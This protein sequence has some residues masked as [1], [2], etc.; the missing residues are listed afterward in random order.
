MHHTK[1]RVFGLTCFILQKNLVSRVCELSLSSLFSLLKGSTACQ[2]RDVPFYGISV[3]IV[4]FPSVFLLKNGLG[5]AK[6][7][8]SIFYFGI[9]FGIIFLWILLTSSTFKDIRYSLKFFLWYLLKLISDIII[10]NH[11]RKMILSR[12]FCISMAKF[13]KPN[14]LKFVTKFYNESLRTVFNI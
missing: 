8:W 13:K 1:F 11:W 12:N 3:N 14:F 9:S 4:F 2:S 6:R 10:K 5:L 7:I